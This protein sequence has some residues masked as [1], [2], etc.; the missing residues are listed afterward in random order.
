MR[1]IEELYNS[2]KPVV[3]LITGRTFPLTKVCQLITNDQAK[4][5]LSGGI[6]YLVEYT[7]RGTIE[8]K[9]KIAQP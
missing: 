9:F 6:A 2:K 4:G 1:F 3:D 7:K 8:Y 5:I